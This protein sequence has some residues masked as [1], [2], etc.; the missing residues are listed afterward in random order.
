MDERVKEQCFLAFC[1]ALSNAVRHA[2]AGRVDVVLDLPSP[3]R[4]RLEIADDG[5]GFDMHTA[6][7][8]PAGL[9]TRILLLTMHD[10]PAAAL[11]EAQEAGVAGYVLKDNSFE[12]LVLAVATVAAGGT[13]LTLIHP[14]QAARTPAPRPHDPYPVAAGTRGHPADRP[15]QQQQGDCPDLRPKPADGR[16]LP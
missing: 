14:R 15:R 3:G 13:F 6:F 8:R 12:E 5:I 7:Q 10:D 9:G 1:E 2:Q 4:L 11:E 16:H